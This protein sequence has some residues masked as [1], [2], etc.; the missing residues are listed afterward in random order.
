MK[1]IIIAIFVCLSLAVLS[2]ACSPT[3]QTV[4][5]TRLVPQTVV[6]TR[7]VT[8]LV[9]VD[10]TPTPIPATVTTQPTATPEPTPVIDMSSQDPEVVIVQF[11]TLIG[12]HLYKE[13]FQ[14]RSSKEQWNSPLADFMIGAERSYQTI[15]VLKVVRYNDWIKQ[16]QIQMPPAKENV[17]YVQLYVIGE[18][19]AEMTP[20]KGVIENYVWAI[21]ENGAVKLEFNGKVPY[22]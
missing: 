22:D 21:R 17:Y 7:L 13:A 3:V 12:L 6:A 19:M 16:N 20:V 14:L 8:Q 18:N 2:S 9:P 1:N 11:Y 15:R 4:E 5:V 10:V